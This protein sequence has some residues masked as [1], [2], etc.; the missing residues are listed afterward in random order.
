MNNQYLFN[1]LYYDYLYKND[2]T[3][4]I[5]EINKKLLGYTL[6]EANV[7]ELKSVNGIRR[8]KLQTVYPGLL[9]GIGN[10]HASGD[11]SK[12]IKLGYTLDYTT[13]L[14]Y[15]P[16]STVKG[17]LR[18]VIKKN[19]NK[20]DNETKDRFG[21]REEA[22]KNRLEYLREIIARI[23]GLSES[24][25]KVKISDEILREFEI[26]TFGDSKKGK[27]DLFLDAYPI[28]GGQGN[29]LFAFESITPHDMFRDPNPLRLLK[30]IPEVVFE[31]R[32]IIKDSMKIPELTAEKKECLFK[33]LL[34][35]FGVGAKTNVGFGLLEEID[36]IDENSHVIDE[37]D[38]IY[39]CVTGY[40]DKKTTAKLLSDTKQKASLYFKNIPGAEYGGIDEKLPINTRVKIKFEGKDD[41][42]FE[43]WKLVE[44][45]D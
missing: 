18:S 15:I 42:G 40:N 9:I 1:V 34:M 45:L 6:K 12:E 37:E 5:D 24:D 31:F 19:D 26:E 17:V 33:Q 3:N 23:T 32:F 7:P 13:G 27:G 22:Y 43:K 29:K 35:D 39:A 21:Y 16:G 10:P 38:V 2:G 8:V 30:I 14:P 44:I 11:N 28:R 36:D 25:A 41:S 4:C 20:R